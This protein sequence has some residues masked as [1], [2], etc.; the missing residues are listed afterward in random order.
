MEAQLAIKK[1][2]EHML[3]MYKEEPI[4]QVGLEEVKFE[5]LDE[6]W[7]ITLGFVRDWRPQGGGFLGLTT[8]KRTYKVVRI[9]DGDGSLESLRNRETAEEN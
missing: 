4:G 8:P 3:E 2:K 6:V 9:H 7:E 1:A 5:H